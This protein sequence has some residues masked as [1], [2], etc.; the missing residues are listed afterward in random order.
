[1][2]GVG[3]DYCLPCI[4]IYIYVRVFLADSRKGGL[5]GR[6]VLWR[7]WFFVGGVEADFKEIGL[8]IGF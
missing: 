2:H 4:Y 6:L 3:D 7:G 5:T 1:M 8:V